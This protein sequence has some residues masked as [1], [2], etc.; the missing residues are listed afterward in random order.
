MVPGNNNKKEGEE[1]KRERKRGRRG[2]GRRKK[3]MG[4]GGGRRGLC[5]NFLKTFCCEV[6]IDKQAIMQRRLTPFTQRIVTP[7]KTMA[8]YHNQEMTVIMIQS[9]NRIQN[10]TSFACTGICVCV[11]VCVYPQLYPTVC[12]P[13]YWDFPSKN[14]GM[15]CH[16]PQ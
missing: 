3:K 12:D 9:I 10:F 6:I 16:F 11:C 5:V 2:D 7:Y 1:E 8:Q 15:G 14:T 13:T 4:E